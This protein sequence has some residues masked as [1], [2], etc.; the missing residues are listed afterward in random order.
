MGKSI[1]VGNAELTP[2]GETSAAPPP[3][4][5]GRKG[6][7]PAPPGV[8]AAVKRKVRA[9]KD[10]VEESDEDW[11]RVSA[12]VISFP[13]RLYQRG[14]VLEWGEVSCAQRTVYAFGE[15]GVR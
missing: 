15:G 2:G 8:L 11:D 10:D 6:T 14:V 4:P 12:R 1:E 3:P 9:G 13:R 7:I 5:D